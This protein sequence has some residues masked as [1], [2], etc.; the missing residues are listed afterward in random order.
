MRQ[1]S[2]R[3]PSSQSSFSD[4]G[5]AKSS[6]DR[7]IVEPGLPFCLPAMPCSVAR[8]CHL[9]VCDPCRAGV[10]SWGLRSFHGGYLLE[11]VAGYHTA[12]AFDNI[13]GIAAL[14]GLSGASQVRPRLPKL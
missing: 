13:L 4:T 10:V 11:E 14:V 2:K 12:D 6:L 3:R 5:P 9:D 1:I 8:A 7:A